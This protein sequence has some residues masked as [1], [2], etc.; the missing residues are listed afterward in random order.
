M[1]IYVFFKRN[2]GNSVRPREKF[3]AHFSGT[4]E[5]IVLSMKANQL[6][7]LAEAFSDGKYSVE[8]D[9][10]DGGLG[11]V[12]YIVDNKAK[13]EQLIKDIDWIGR[14]REFANNSFASNSIAVMHVIEYYRSLRKGNTSESEHHARCL[15]KKNPAF[16]LI[17]IKWD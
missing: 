5:E 1:E 17:E 8:D 11:G 3:V 6:H 15:K 14:V 7:N 16:G 13:A 2:S 4:K 12:H 9:T 10:Q